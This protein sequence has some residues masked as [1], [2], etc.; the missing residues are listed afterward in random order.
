[1]SLYFNLCVKLYL[2]YINT[3]YAPFPYVPYYPPKY[4]YPL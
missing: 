2:P 1:M 3:K 4:L